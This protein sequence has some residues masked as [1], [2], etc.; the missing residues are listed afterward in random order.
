MSVITQNLESVGSL[1]SEYYRAPQVPAHSTV[2][3]QLSSSAGY[4]RLPNGTICYS[5][6]AGTEPAVA[7]KGSLPEAHLQISRREAAIQLSF[8]P[9]EAIA[10]LQ[11]ERYERSGQQGG[12]KNSIV[13]RLYYLLRPALPT[14]LRKYFQRI[15][16]KGWNNIPFPQWPVD[17]TV[18]SLYEMLL[19][20]SMQAQGADEI[21]FVWFWP[22]GSSACATV[23]HDIE[24]TAGRDFCSALMDIND[25]FAIKTSFQVVPEERYEVTESFLDSIRSRGFEVNVHDLN[26]DGNLFV[27]HDQFLDRV[28]KINAYGEKF[29]ARGFRSAVLYRNL[30]WMDALDFEYDMSVPNVAHLDPQRGGCCTV[31]PYFAG[32]RL[33]IPVTAIQDYSLFH[34]LSDYSTRLWEQQINIIKDAHGLASFIVH[35]DYVIERRARSTYERLLAH[36]RSLREDQNVWIALPGEIND[37]WR[38]RAKMRVSHVNGC[39]Q[40]EGEGSERARVAFASIENDRLRYRIQ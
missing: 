12:N 6:L 38:S 22:N 19:V 15:Y 35:P 10:N 8:D 5:R 26:H 1:L 21:P 20:A 17:R 9:E 16:L 39:W 33:E 13:R 2:D 4:Y 29:G 18:D 40:V 31:M 11:F 27:D 36:L 30:E 32:N 23:T 28:K 24:T 14:S 37:W 3:E 25:S 7:P 34:I